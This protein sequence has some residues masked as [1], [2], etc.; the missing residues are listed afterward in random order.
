[1]TILCPKM[2]IL[3]PKRV[4]N[5]HFKPRKGPKWPVRGLDG[6]HV[7]EIAVHA[8]KGPCRLF[9]APESPQILG[10]VVFFRWSPYWRAKYYH[11]L[12]LW[13]QVGTA[14]LGNSHALGHMTG[15]WPGLI[16]RRASG[17]WFARSGA[18]ARDLRERE[19]TD[20]LDVKSVRLSPSFF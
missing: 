6:R 7:A 10:P 8:P 19:E 2:T 9:W 3:S 15:P 4:Q 18:S 17:A 16:G 13:G 12:G 14:W 5:G 1:M 20:V 11:G